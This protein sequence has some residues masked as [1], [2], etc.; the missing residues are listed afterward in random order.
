IFSQLKQFWD[1]FCPPDSPNKYVFVPLCGK[2]LDL[3]WMY[4]N[5]GCTVVGC[6]LS[7]T[8]LESFVREHSI[9]GMRRSNV[10][11]KNGQLV[12]MFHTEDRKL[13]LYLCDLF[14]MDQSPETQFNFIWDRGSLV[15]MAPALH[16]KSPETQFNFIWDRGSLVAMAPAL[17][18][19]YVDYI[20]TLSSADVRWLLETIDYPEGIYDGPPCRIPKEEFRELFDANFNSTLLCRTDFQ[21]RL[22][23][24][25]EYCFT[26]INLLTRKPKA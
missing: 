26:Y 18:R 17:H 10:Q 20:N 21:K 3:Q 4:L 22:F 1:I 25:A 11:F 13:R 7:E 16:R 15:A 5:E 19:K 8:A 14:L 2:S 12:V 9:L 6:D 24:N 23:Q